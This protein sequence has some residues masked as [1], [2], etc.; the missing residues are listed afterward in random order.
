[1]W[2]PLF[3]RSTLMVLFG[4]LALV[5]ISACSNTKTDSSLNQT[6]NQSS[7]PPA[8]SAAAAPAK[9]KKPEASSSAKQPQSA[10]AV[11]K[12]QKAMDV[13]MG[14]VTISKSAASRDD[15]SLVANH[16]QEAIQHLK[17]VP[18]TSRQYK[19]AQNKIAEYKGY[20]AD[21]KLKAT[22]APSKP[23]SGQTNPAYFSVPIKGRDG[24]TPIVEVNFNGQKFDMLFDTG[25]SQTL[26]TASMAQALKVPFAGIEGAR[27][28]D[29]SVMISPVGLV[30]SQEIDGRYRMEVKVAIAPPQ[31]EMGLLGQDFYRGYDVSIKENVIEFRYQGS[32]T[33]S[34][35]KADCL[36]Q[37][38]PKVFSV[39]VTGR[40]HNI[41][42]VQV[43]FNDKYTFPLM[44]DTGASGTVITRKMAMKMKLKPTGATPAG[45]ANG[46]VVTFTTANVK[47]QRIA[48]RVKRDVEVMV[49]P[50]AMDIGLLGQD[51]FEGYEYTIKSDT[52]E[53]TRVDP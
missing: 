33:G 8:A 11:D 45:I 19:T 43:T 49:A 32:P 41:P 10:N 46:S 12:Y 26:I 24:G 21:A 17:A 4:S 51:F 6:V 44:F 37:S 2:K 31:M 47:S 48:N 38:T 3:S 29:G 36:T 23:C 16:W 42:I 28:A 39:P 35:I 22:P 50:P 13:A 30:K 1:M 9:P 5:S 14:A 34:D 7:I 18:K 52:I 25:A 53:F 27:I 15:W 40:K 20:L